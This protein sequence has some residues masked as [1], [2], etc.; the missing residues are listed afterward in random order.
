MFFSNVAPGEIASPLNFPRALY[1]VEVTQQDATPF[2][3]MTSAG[4]MFPCLSSHLNC[5]ILDDALDV[6]VASRLPIRGPYVILF[7]AADP[8]KIVLLHFPP[9]IRQNQEIHIA[10]LAFGGGWPLNFLPTWEL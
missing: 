2:R 1:D 10:Q 5:E 3:F 6:F 7:W 8:V 4:H 9:V